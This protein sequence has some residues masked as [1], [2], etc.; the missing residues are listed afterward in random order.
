[1]KLTLFLTFL[2]GLVAAT[3]T[4]NLDSRATKSP[5]KVTYRPG[6]IEGDYISLPSSKREDGPAEYTTSTGK[7]TL[8]RPAVTLKKLPD[9]Y[10]D[11]GLPKRRESFEALKQLR[12]QVS[13]ADFFECY[14]SVSFLSSLRF[15]HFNPSSPPATR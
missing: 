8:V 12:R 5:R 13:A 11:N 14:N 2:V 4:I 6:Q 15:H 10:I 9:Q 1:M 3:E 7:A